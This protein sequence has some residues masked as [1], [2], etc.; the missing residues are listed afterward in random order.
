MIQCQ[1][2]HES[3]YAMMQL[4]LETENSQI[5]YLHSQEIYS[6]RNRNRILIGKQ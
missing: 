2:H 6:G 3:V 1:I 5:T 4:K